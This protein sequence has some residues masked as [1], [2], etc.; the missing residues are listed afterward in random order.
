M[1][2]LSLLSHSANTNV[3]NRQ[4]IRPPWLFLL[5]YFILSAAAATVVFGMYHFLPV[6]VLQNNTVFNRNHWTSSQ[7]KL[8]RL[9]AGVAGYEIHTLA[10][11][12]QLPVP[13]TALPAWLDLS[14]VPLFRAKF[15]CLC[16][17]IVLRLFL[18]YIHY[19][20]LFCP[21]DSPRRERFAYIVC[22]EP[23]IGQVW[24]IT[25]EAQSIILAK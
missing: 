2:P 14:I 5:R 9:S 16:S 15:S 3:V 23:F 10:V 21:Q 1:S 24:G 20:F 12:S 17:P 4:R 8:N 6:A 11:R 7:W 22:C 19:A 25:T 13:L 18:G